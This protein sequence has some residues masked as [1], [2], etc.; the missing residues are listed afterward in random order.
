M[1]YKKEITFKMIEQKDLEGQP[2]KYS[3]VIDAQIRHVI[4]HMGLKVLLI[5][6]LK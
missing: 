1:I 3:V 2:V 4:S 5:S 6:I